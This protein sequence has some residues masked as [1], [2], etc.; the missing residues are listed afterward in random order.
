[1]VDYLAASF[2][3][4]VPG[5][6][7]QS[8]PKD[9][10]MYAGGLLFPQDEKRQQEVYEAVTSAVPE[11]ELVSPYSGWF[12]INYRGWN[13]AQGFETLIEAIGLKPEEVI[14]CGDSENDLDLLKL[15]PHSCC[16]ENGTDE[17]KAVSKYLLPS[18]YEEGVSQLL[19]ALTEAQGDFDSEVVQAVLK[20]T[21]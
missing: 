14:V 9:V 10:P 11:V 15:A 2:N 21:L 12:D 16:M 20:R 5:L 19:E 8:V 13:K 1:M 7:P 3:T 17:A 6:G 18:V 4:F